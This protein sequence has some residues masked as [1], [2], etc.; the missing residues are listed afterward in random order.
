MSRY[1]PVLSDLSAKIKHVYIE[2]LDYKYFHSPYSEKVYPLN[3]TNENN[4]DG[5]FIGRRHVLNQII[6]ILE[7]S[8]TRSGAY[9]IAG[10]RGMGKTSAVRMAIREYHLRLNQKDAPAKSPGKMHSFLKT[11][12]HR[13][14]KST[15][16]TYIRSFVILLVMLGLLYWFSNYP[17]LQFTAALLRLLRIHWIIAVL[18]GC[19]FTYITTIAL[20][21]SI[22]LFLPPKRAPWKNKSFADFE[23]NLS[24]EEIL[25]VDVLKRITKEVLTYWQGMDDNLFEKF[26]RPIYQPIRWVS[27]ALRRPRSS[28]NPR[29]KYHEIQKRLMLLSQRISAQV[30][31]ENKLSLSPNFTIGLSSGL[32]RFATPL[33]G[34]SKNE[35]AIYPIANAKEI[36]DELIDIFKV[37]DD[38]RNNE[39]IQRQGIHIPSFI[40]VIDELDKIEPHYSGNISER[41]SSDPLLDMQKM[42]VS[43]SD[44]TRQR[45]ESVAKLLA[46]LKGF[47][48]VVRAKFFFIGGRELYDASLADIA[49]R[50]SFY[51]SVF[52]RI[53]YVNSFFKDKEDERAGIT[54]MTE[55]YLCKLILSSL[56]ESTPTPQ[57]EKKFNLK[58]LYNSLRF[59]DQELKIYSGPPP[60]NKESFIERLMKYKVLVL[61]QNYII[62]LT[63]RSNGTPKKLATLIEKIIT[64]REIPKETRL[65]NRFLQNNLVVQHHKEEELDQESNLNRLFLRFK[66]D[67][68]YEIGLTAYIYRPFLIVNSRHLKV[69]GDKL[70]FSTAFIFDHILKFHSYSFSWR[71]LELIP[72]VILVNKEPNLRQ[73]IE[74]LIHFLSKNQIRDTV[75]GINQYRFF[76][77]IDTELKFLSKIS[78]LS[79]AA[80]NFTLDESLQI[81]RH[82]KRKLYEL[83]KKY[84]GYQPIKG[85]NQFVHSISFVQTILGDLHYYDKEYDEALI[86]YTESIQTIR[87][88]NSRD[89]TMTR[90]QFFIWLRNNLKA[91]LTLEKMRAFES[92]FSY[93]TSMCIEISYYLETVIYNGITEH[94][95]NTYRNIQMLSMPYVA[96][97]AVLEKSRNDGITYIN[98]KEKEVE[99]R[100]VLS[101]ETQDRKPGIYGIRIRKDLKLDLYRKFLLIA[102]YY[103]NVG[104]ILFY[105]NCQYPMLFQKKFKNL[106]YLPSTLQIYLSKVYSSRSSG[107][108]DYQPAISAFIYFYLSAK[109]LIE[110]HR[111]RILEEGRKDDKLPHLADDS[112]LQLIPIL[113]LPPCIDFINSGRAYYIA[114][115]LSKL[116]DSVLGCLQPTDLKA[117]PTWIFLSLVEHKKNLDIRKIQTFSDQLSQRIQK[118]NFFSLETV[119]CLYELAAVFYLRSSREQSFNY[120]YRKILYLIKDVLGYQNDHNIQ[121]GLANFS[122]DTVEII[123]CQLF[124]TITW[125]TE[126]SNRPQILKYREIFQIDDPNLDR[127]LIYNS[128]NSAPDTREIALLVEKIRIRYHQVKG[129]KK[130]NKHAFFQ[131]YFLSSYSSINHR[132]VRQQELE[133]KADLYLF[134]AEHII[135][136]KWLFDKGEKTTDLINKIPA[137]QKIIEDLLPKDMLKDTQDGLY[138]I[139]FIVKESIFC[140]RELIRSINIYGLGSFLSYSYIAFAHQSLGTWCQAYRNILRYENSTSFSF[141]ESLSEEVEAMIGNNALA[142][143]EPN[144]HFEQAIQFYYKA[145]QL[146][147][148]G[149][150]YKD[151]ILN[152]YMLEDEYNDNLRHFVIGL[153]RQRVNSGRIRRRISAL[154]DLIQPSRLYKYTSYYPIHD[155][156]NLARELA[157]LLRPILSQSM[158]VSTIRKILMRQKNLWPEITSVVTDPFLYNQQKEVLDDRFSNEVR[159]TFLLIKLDGTDKLTKVSDMKKFLR[160]INKR[161]IEEWEKD[162]VYFKEPLLSRYKSNALELMYKHK[163]EITILVKSQN[164][165]IQPSYI[166]KLLKSLRDGLKGS[167]TINEIDKR[168]SAQEQAWVLIE[169]VFSKKKKQ[170]RELNLEQLTESMLQLLL[171]IPSEKVSEIK[172][173]LENKM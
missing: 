22:D 89:I 20:F 153:E 26:N 72:E 98:L 115:V 32:G 144:F 113:L 48:N 169:S 35:Q 69:L 142:Y 111:E 63:Y 24:Q 173:L 30:T 41:E 33:G 128:I 23:I 4:S 71:N 42:D 75:S 129:D 140:L 53:I 76:N 160:D 126:V 58:E 1:Q 19:I 21:F 154:Q 163:K 165:K 96:F 134:L 107:N 29:K 106:H 127:S 130:Y 124:K 39:Q 138:Y 46:N 36:E 86:Y 151:N 90:H 61:L 159:S 47:L 55:T 7:N 108:L 60:D 67:F 132:Y 172:T 123:A 109:Y 62:Y 110:Y 146:H 3:S 171:D 12:W 6:E 28:T 81:K 105:K 52:N 38:L 84:E 93:Y 161:A 68:Q 77:K 10:F 5:R 92:A 64:Q 43:T 88:P 34:I 59:T 157:Q 149:R 143:L 136:I 83:Q 85:D 100:K 87:L 166:I 51:S 78:D 118:N 17:L 56:Q 152:I 15:W 147:T 137:I 94:S 117:F 139:K 31:A 2:L 80:F 97:L 156:P 18:S 133:Y 119:F 141:Q 99:L 73:F 11:I 16:S 170:T 79:A 91:A 116:G 27:Q 95:F 131:N 125:A 8:K 66:F 50:D 162:L 37:I 155:I 57:R 158:V 122:M 70:L 150:S 25:E 40:F 49:D 168:L 102:D 54:Q 167:A 44:L 114:N 145:I 45:Q 65:R 13:I 9:L 164:P 120:Q 104:S 148:E 74:E 121:N 82:Y 101:L 135:G 112:C 103:N 14:I